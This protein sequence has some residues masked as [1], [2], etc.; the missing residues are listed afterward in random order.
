LRSDLPGFLSLESTPKTPRFCAPLHC[1]RTPQR[2]PTDAT[3]LHQKEQEMAK[4]AKP[5]KKYRP[6]PIIADPIR[7]VTAAVRPAPEAAQLKTKIGIHM[8]MAK[9][10]KGEGDKDDWQEVAN[11]L[12]LSLI[13]AEMGYGQEYVQTVVMGQA[14]MTLLRDRFKATGKAILRGEEMR[15]INE[16]LEVH[17][18]QIE[19]ATV[20]DIERAVYAVERELA[21]GNFVKVLPDAPL[22]PSVQ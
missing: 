13:L 22:R 17:D 9:I 2:T 16:A 12:N 21:R 6:R 14:A 4:S 7:Y 11:A 1:Q 10:T 3:E 19:L 20:K 5:K 15:A 18:G 8:A